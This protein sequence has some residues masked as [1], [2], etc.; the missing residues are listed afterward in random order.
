[1]RNLTF[2][3]YINLTAVTFFALGA[4]ATQ[5]WTPE[6]LQGKQSFHEGP[7]CFNAALVGKGYLDNLIYT[8]A[9]EY[10]FFLE[11]F[12]SPVSS[13][14][15]NSKGLLYA[16]ERE[17]RLEHGFLSIG[18]GTI[19]EKLST[20]GVFS[21]YDD[22][23][24]SSFYRI[25]ELNDS[26]YVA[27]CKENCIVRAFSCKSANEVRAIIQSCGVRPANGSIESLRRSLS[28]IALTSNY[29][30]TLDD[31]VL[32]KFE[33][34]VEDVKNLSGIDECDLYAL[35]AGFSLDW[36]I[37]RFNTE[38]PLDKKWLVTYAK[39]RK[40]LRLLGD[41]IKSRDDSP[42]LTRILNE[43]IYWQADDC[44]AWQVNPRKC[45]GTWRDFE[46]DSDP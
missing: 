43:I 24:S 20:A 33:S 6:T 25:K 34:L 8:D 21:H 18:T 45:L 31:T 41:R 3:L 38:R 15:D 26:P 36:A 28:S 37:D 13:T 2:L 16:V 35:V 4:S 14:P 12:C 9:I 7:N 32:A 27:S 39:L 40:Q 30:Y 5:A 44:V 22:S 23:V 11:K 46:K 42:Q 19:F 17:S 1:M 29:N 10:R